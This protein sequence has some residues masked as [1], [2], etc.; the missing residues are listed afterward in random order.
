MIV[1]DIL[2]YHLLA[3]YSKLALSRMRSNRSKSV[4]VGVFRTLHLFQLYAK[5]GGTVGCHLYGGRAVGVLQLVGVH[6]L[7]NPG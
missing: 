2:A 6:S 3:S 4:L 7:Q 1:K 5:G